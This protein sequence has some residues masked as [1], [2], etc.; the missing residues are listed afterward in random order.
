MSLNPDPGR[1][2]HQCENAFHQRACEQPFPNAFSFKYEKKNANEKLRDWEIAFPGFEN[3]FLGVEE[4]KRNREIATKL[5]GEVAPI[6]GP[7]SDT[8][9]EQRKSS[10]KTFVPKSRA[11]S[12]SFCATVNCVCV[13]CSHQSQGILWFLMHVDK[14]LYAENVRIERQRPRRSMWN[15]VEYG[16]SARHI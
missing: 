16:R 7:T 11:F 6:C 12:F 15:I 10:A 13:M 4:R 9:G 8:F 2:H 1:R 3:G 14:C 5:N